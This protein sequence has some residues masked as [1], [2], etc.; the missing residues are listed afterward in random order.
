M[1]KIAKPI[2]LALVLGVGAASAAMA[3]GAAPEDNPMKTL[4]DD[5]YYSSPVYVEPSYRSYDYRY[6]QYDPYYR[7]A[8]AFGL[9]LYFGP[10]R[11]HHRHHYRHRHRHHG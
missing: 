7:S 6:G 5:D 1:K 9:G 8:P 4:R 11:H 3:D 2:A 10:D